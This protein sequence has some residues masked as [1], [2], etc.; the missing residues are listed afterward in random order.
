M[1]KDK[2]ERAIVV[3]GEIVSEDSS[4]LPGENTYK[5][6]GKIVA[7]RFGVVDDLGK[8]IKIVPISGVYEPRR[9]N[10]VIGIVT[11]ITFNGWLM[12][13]DCSAGGFLPLMDYPRF[14]NKNDL[15]E[16]LR[17]GDVVYAKIMGV[18]KKGID[19]TMKQRGLI[20]IEGGILIKVNA[21]KIPRVIGKEGS[22]IITIRNATGCRIIAGQNGLVSI[23]GE[24]KDLELLTIKAIRFVE[25]NSLTSGLT[26]KVTEMLTAEL[27]RLGKK[28]Q[29]VPQEESF[30]EA[31]E[32]SE[33][34]DNKTE[35][36]E[37]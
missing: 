2:N 33:S 24:D 26:D 8:V 20:K 3:P 29:I 9:G 13:I 34:K 25:E 17:I 28:P 15:E 10:N 11:D 30:G 19:L 1:S 31:E 12:D 32:S 6:N 7:S 4:K 21:Q 22:M 18:K 14:V 37:E 23:R 16:H 5:E 27:K 35:G 36:D